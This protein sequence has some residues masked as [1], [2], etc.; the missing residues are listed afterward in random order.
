MNL[1]SSESLDSA[2]NFFNGPKTGR[3]SRE[4]VAR[5]LQ[6]PLQPSGLIP[7]E[8]PVS[9]L[10]AEDPEDEAPRSTRGS[11]ATSLSIQSYSDGSPVQHFLSG[12]ETV[13]EGVLRLIERMTCPSS[14]DRP[15]MQEVANA[16]AVF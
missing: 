7:D 12:L 14:A 13:P 8:P 6:E 10:A 3:L 1:G 5:L 9:S 15:T 4:A 2:G 11:P 16:L